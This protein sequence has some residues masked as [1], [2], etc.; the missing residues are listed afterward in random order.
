MVLSRL[1][2]ALKLTDRKLK[3]VAVA[4]LVLDIVDVASAVALGRVETL[5]RLDLLI[6]L[7]EMAAFYVLFFPLTMRL[8]RGR[9]DAVDM[10]LLLILLYVLMVANMFKLNPVG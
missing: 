2:K 7:V 5:M 10:T 6:T 3:A 8:Q 4:L 1:Y 9:A